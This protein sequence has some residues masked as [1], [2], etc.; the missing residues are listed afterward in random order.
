[1][2]V[3]VCDLGF[4]S[5]K[6]IYC[7]RKGRIISAF[8]YNGENLLIGEEALVLWSHITYWYWHG[9]NAINVT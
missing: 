8:S 2:D 5:A 4:S 7:G 9:Y 1:M 6:W 3:L